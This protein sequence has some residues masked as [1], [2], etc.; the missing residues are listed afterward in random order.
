MAGE[1]ASEHRQRDWCAQLFNYATTPI[2]RASNQDTSN[3]IGKIIG[4]TIGT[5]D[6]KH[7]QNATAFES[8]PTYF[9]RAGLGQPSSTACST[10]IPDT[11]SS[12]QICSELRINCHDRP[13]LST[14]GWS[15]F[16]NNYG[17]KILLGDNMQLMV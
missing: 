6:N 5:T 1:N 3:A 17:R 14:L 11:A 2:S 7:I 10:A 9:V 13:F 4:R 8:S 15:Y 12:R 16:V